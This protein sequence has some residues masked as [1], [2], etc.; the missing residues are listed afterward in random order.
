MIHTK[1]QTGLTRR[2]RDGT[3]AGFREVMQMA[4]Q[5]AQAAVQKQ[6]TKRQRVM[7]ALVW[8]KYAA[9]V[10]LAAAAFPYVRMRGY[11]G[12]YLY[13]MARQRD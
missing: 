8:M 10:P 2:V 5:Q 9:C 7:Q 3:P 4:P 13:C 6:L 11:K 1:F 12:S